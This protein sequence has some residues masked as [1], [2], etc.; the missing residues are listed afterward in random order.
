MEHSRSSGRQL[1]REQQ[2]I[3]KLYSDWCH[4]TYATY[5]RAEHDASIRTSISQNDEKWASLRTSRLGTR[6]NLPPQRAEPFRSQLGVSYKHSYCLD[7]H[8]YNSYCVRCSDKIHKFLMSC[9]TNYLR[10]LWGNVYLRSG[11]LFFLK[12]LLSFRRRARYHVTVKY[13]AFVFAHE[14]Q[15]SVCGRLLTQVL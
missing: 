15:K 7:L 3:E 8:A 5:H 14:F 12:D 9:S 6:Y 4:Y 2:A 1:V 11:L 13:C 10:F